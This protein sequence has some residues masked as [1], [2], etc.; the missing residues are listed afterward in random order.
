VV[1]N[2]NTFQDISGMFSSGRQKVR[3][4]LLLINLIGLVSYKT[5]KRIYYFLSILCRSGVSWRKL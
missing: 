2:Y 3:S 5:R 1:L 4:R